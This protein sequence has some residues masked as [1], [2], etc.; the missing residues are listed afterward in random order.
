[1]PLAV[2][3]LELE[4]RVPRSRRPGRPRAQGT[5]ARGGRRTGARGGWGRRASCGSPVWAGLRGRPCHTNPRPG[6][7]Q[8]GRRLAASDSETNYLFFENREALV[9][10][11]G[12]A[13]A[14]YQV[15]VLGAIADWLPEDAACPFEVLVG[16]SAGALNAATLVSRAAQFPRRRGR[17]RGRLVRIQGGARGARRPGHHHP[18]GPALG[19]CPLPPGA[20]CC[21]RRARCSTPRRCASCCCARYPWTASGPASRRAWC[22]RWRS[23]PPAIRPARPW[24]SSTALPRSTEWSRVRRAGVRRHIDIEVL[25]ASSAIPFIFP[26]G[27]VDGD[28]YG[29]GAMRQLAPLAPPCTWART[30]C[31]SWARARKRR[32]RP[33]MARSTGR[34]APV[35]CSASCSTR[36]SPTACPSTSSA[37]GRSMPS[38]SRTARGKIPDRRP[39]EALVIEPSDDPTALARR[40]LRRDAAQPANLLRTIGA[41]EARGGLLASYLLFESAY[42]TELMRLGRADAE[43]RRARDRGV[44]RRMTGTFSFSRGYRIRGPA[45]YPL[46][47]YEPGDIPLVPYP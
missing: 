40:H 18:G 28:Y 9:L 4:W 15:G 10:A 44:P 8:R 3:V 7:C 17:A 11:G 38:C 42:T 45:G 22:G 31:W 41:L 6:P 33:P 25:M 32:R 27:Q 20:G 36:C 12:G 21:R 39:I 23:R 35:T 1:M 29:D 24:R 16:T 30:G 13:R 46:G 5:R 34:P 19:R 43:A 26:A 37:C 47:S 2:L 14:A